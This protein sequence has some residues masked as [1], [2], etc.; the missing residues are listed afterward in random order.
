MKTNY[1]KISL[2]PGK[3][4]TLRRFHPWVFSGAIAGMSNATNGASKIENE[5]I[6][7]GKESSKQKKDSFSPKA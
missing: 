3:E 4:S 7:E 6:K 2:K 5:N 1:I